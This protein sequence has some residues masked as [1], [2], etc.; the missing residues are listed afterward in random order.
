MRPD[1]YVSPPRSQPSEAGLPSKALQILIIVALIGGGVAGWKRYGGS[2][3][4]D[5]WEHNMAT[6]LNTAR[7]MSKPALV[8]FTADW[9]PPCRELKAGVLAEERVIQLLDNR[10][11][12][13]KVDLSDRNGPNTG[14]SGQ[15][16]V[17]TIPTVIVFDMRGRELERVVGGQ[18]LDSWFRHKAVPSTR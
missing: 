15:F 12:L 4:R 1:T 16:N 7:D 10:Y 11:V 14:L 9:C 5:K 13:V 2:L 17:G 3:G 6:G 18:R 8:F